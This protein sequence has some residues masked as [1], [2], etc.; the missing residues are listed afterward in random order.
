M[1]SDMMRAAQDLF[2]NI[3]HSQLAQNLTKTGLVSLAERYGTPQVAA[4][5]RTNFD[6]IVNW[7]RNTLL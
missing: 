1:P 7:I 4:F 2:R 5:V 6:P 3:L